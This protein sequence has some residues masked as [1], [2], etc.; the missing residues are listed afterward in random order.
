MSALAVVDVPVGLST[1][2]RQL[3]VAEAG[4]VSEG[5]SSSKGGKQRQKQ[6]PRIPP[7]RA[8]ARQADH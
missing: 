8:V 3:P 7:C 2:K 4:D 6:T 1:Q 5:F